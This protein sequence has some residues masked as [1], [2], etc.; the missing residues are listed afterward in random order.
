[1]SVDTIMY[2]KRLIVFF[3]F[4]FITT[5]LFS[6]QRAQ[7][8]E[9]FEQSSVILESYPGQDF[10]PNDW[11]IDS[12]NTHNNSQY[13]LKLFGNTWKVEQI[14][15]ITLDSNS[16][17]TVS[18]LVETKGEIHGF[19]IMDSVNVLM[20]SLDGHEELNIEEF[21]TVYQ[22][23]FPEQVWDTYYLPV[24]DD[25]FAWFEY[26][27][28][29]T[30][31]LFINDL[32]TDPDGV[33]YFDDIL[34]V[35]EDLPAIPEVDIW[36]SRGRE[37]M[38]SF[39][40]RNLDVQF[41][42]E[43][44]DPDSDT[45]FYHWDFGDGNTSSVENPAH[46]YVIYDD[47]PYN[48][49]LEVTDDTGMIGRANCQIVPDQGTSSF[50]ITMN[51]IGDILLARG[52]E[53][54][55]GIIQTYGVEAIFEPTLNLL[56]NAADVTIAN[57]ECPL[58][59]QGTPHPTKPIYF[60]GDPDNVEGLSYAGID[61][62]TLANNHILDYGLIGLQQTQDVLAQEQ[63]LYSGAGANSYEA[64]TP[65]LYTQNGVTFAFL[66][67]SDRTGQ[68]N[69][70]QPYL[71]AGYNKPGFA[72]MTP[73][74]ISQQIAEVEDVSDLQIIEMHAGSE[75]SLAPGSQYDKSEELNPYQDEG[76]NPK[77]DVPHMWD[78]AI[79]QHAIDAGA[80]L[81]I[82]HHPH[83]IQGFE[84]YHNKL[85]A[86]SLGN[87]VFDLM[88]PETMP[89]MI[90]NA[91]I[92]ENGFYEY[93]V[94]PAYI[95]DWIP[96]PAT[97][98]FGLH[99]LDYLAYRSK[100]LN[101]YIYVDRDSVYAKIILDTLNMNVNSQ[102]FTD[103]ITLQQTDDYSMSAPQ[104]TTHYANISE[105]SS[106]SPIGDWEYR[107]GK[108]NVWFGNMEDEGCTMWDLIEPEEFY[109]NT[110]H[111]EGQRSLAHEWD[112]NNYYDL[113]TNFEGRLKR[114]SDSTNYSLHGCIKTQNAGGVNIQV[115]Y[116]E[117]R[118][119]SY[120]LGS[121]YVTTDIVGDTDWTYYYKV[122]NMPANTNYIDIY[123]KSEAP[124]SGTS[125]AWF[126]NVGII[127]WNDWRSQD[128]NPYIESPNDWYYYQVRT[129]DAIGNA[130]VK[131][132]ETAYGPLPQVGV[133]DPPEPQPIIS[134]LFNY[135]NP[136][137]GRT[138]ISFSLNKIYD[139]IQLK[140][141][142]IRGQ[143]V[144]LEELYSLKSGKNEY[145]WD[146]H[147]NDGKE[148]ANGIYFYSISKGKEILTTQKC[149]ILN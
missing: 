34:N 60:R 46:T 116:Y 76:Y 89:T 32:D 25:W 118:W 37:Y 41:F 20:Y 22:G 126:D 99:I 71:N 137:K 115:R 51:F 4:L 38:D 143:L 131:Y 109:D 139:N 53:N 112:S 12:T 26:Y 148:V 105:M 140:I 17:W 62:V 43:V 42:S 77:A 123:L 97:G 5:L 50:P 49:F 88:Y 86:H 91:K 2:K 19:G 100:E 141:Y 82:C 125:Y 136:I 114:Y 127:E 111:Y 133:S 120:L 27:P 16:V 85:I 61:I 81:V 15:P 106:I 64:Y 129:D 40:K 83:I 80:D 98:E 134:S 58:T 65:I 18:A 101:T 117:T 44:F 146:L 52:Y 21:I 1:M 55:G 87:F 33:V 92:N 36:S 93:R 119:Y 96:Q 149:V 3:T 142:N 45:L 84:V 103:Y 124:S 78:R 11:C 135:P 35:T 108:E 9:D 59:D 144:R 63:I 48:V 110:V 28:T 69:N 6:H 73:Y 147:D 47:H 107:L 54:P 122:L 10:D 94:K 74:Y 13:S 30:A 138:T 67:S 31:L 66:A 8:I 121:D 95:D 145:I 56:G 29:I 70:Y 57:L 14:T 132:I 39:G 90:L 113:I 130:T 102:I 23:A 24:T 104:K 128:T 79:R 7:V 75:Y 72:Y 68:Y